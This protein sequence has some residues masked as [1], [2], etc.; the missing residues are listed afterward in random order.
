MLR[1]PLATIAGTTTLV[2]Q[3]GGAA[4]VVS[5]GGGDDVIT[6]GASQLEAETAELVSAT[7]DNGKLLPNADGEKT[8]EKT[9][10]GVMVPAPPEAES[11]ITACVKTRALSENK[12]F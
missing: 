5:Q 7:G 4:K 1:D 12:T 6:T 2:S 9:P 8:A 10:P 11:K 3:G